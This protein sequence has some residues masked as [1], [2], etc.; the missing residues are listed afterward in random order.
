MQIKP[1]DRLQLGCMKLQPSEVDINILNKIIPF[2]KDWSCLL[3]SLIEKGIAPLFFKIYVPFISVNYIPEEYTYKLKSTY[4][5]VLSRNILFQNVFS[6]LITEFTKYSI[7]FIPLKGIYLSEWLYGD[8]GLRQLSD[9][10]ILIKPEDAKRTLFLL[11]S[12]GFKSQISINEQIEKDDINLVHFSPMMLNGISIEVHIK[13]LK[14]NFI[15]VES[16]WEHS[17]KCFISNQPV[18]VLWL[19]DMLIHVCLHLNKHMLNGTMQFTGW[20]DIVNLLEKYVG[21]EDWEELLK[22]CDLFNCRSVVFM[23]IILAKEYM[24]ATVPEYIYLKYRYLLKKD[25]EKLFTKYLNGYKGFYISNKSHLKT[26]NDLKPLNKKIRYLINIVFPPKLYIIN[27]YS[28]KH[29]YLY[30]LFYPYRW[31]KGLKS[32]IKNRII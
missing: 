15:P 19:H 20:L 3:T 13:L 8:M 24:N 12:L 6:Q 16:I 10:D 2:I 18:K 7:S 17:V 5:K 25:Y 28:I 14:D 27:K 1:E 31:F 30:V 26:L 23:Q 22:R 21:N 9:I 11:E 29:E 4:Y 32:L